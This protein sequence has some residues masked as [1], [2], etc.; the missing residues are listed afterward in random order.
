[1]EIRANCKINVG[2]HILD[3]RPD[4]YHNIETIMYPIVDFY[5]TIRV[6]KSADFSLVQTGIVA[7]CDVE[8]NLVV[9]CFRL[10]EQRF[11]NITNVTIK[12]HK[13]IPFGAGLGGGSSDAVAMAKALNQL[14]DLQLTNQQLQELVRPL[15][16]DCP[17]FVENKPALCEGIG[18]KI[19]LVEPILATTHIALIKP[20]VAISTKE[21]YANVSLKNR[22]L[23]A[24]ELQNIA[25]FH[26]DFEDYACGR[27]PILQAIKQDL[28]QQGAFYVAMSGSGSC[29][30][31]LFNRKPTIKNA[32]IFTLWKKFYW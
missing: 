31:G 2:L 20:D 8:K 5:D 21:A 17:F 9:K 13:N 22:H 29:M 23:P 1:M 28:L 27:F 32:Y 3:E 6:E 18:E 12:L 7:D 16:A 14:F 25:D 24:W 11:P 15:G 4:G 19:T 26:N 10:F 30:Y